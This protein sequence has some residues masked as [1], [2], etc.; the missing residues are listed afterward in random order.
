MLT[1]V[2]FE[3]LIRRGFFAHFRAVLLAEDV[4]RDEFPVFFDAPIGPAIAGGG[5]FELSANLVD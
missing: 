2:S 5:V 4:D 3:L 1:M